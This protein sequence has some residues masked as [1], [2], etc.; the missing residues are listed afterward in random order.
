MVQH[1]P[2]ERPAFLHRTGEQAFWAAFVHKSAEQAFWAAF[3]HRTRQ[4]LFAVTAN[5]AQSSKPHRSCTVQI[6][7]LWSSAAPC[8]CLLLG[9]VTAASS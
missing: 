4:G 3:L 6:I 1:T 9:M 2:D 8:H 7:L 5:A